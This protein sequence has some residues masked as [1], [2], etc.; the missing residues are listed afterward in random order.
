MLFINNHE[1]CVPFCAKLDEFLKVRTH[2]SWFI[3]YVYVHW[4]RAAAVFR[5]Q[6]FELHTRMK[7]KQVIIFPP[8]YFLFLV[9]S[10]LIIYTS[11]NPHF[12]PNVKRVSLLIWKLNIYLHVDDRRWWM[13]QQGP[14]K[15]YCVST[16]L[17]GATPHK[18][19]TLKFLATN[20]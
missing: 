5:K 4:E 11:Q 13:W 3:D 9:F 19:L 15:H 8:H 14:I 20:T 17:H 12:S 2:L 16:V 7:Q 10:L 18:I 1:R 6:K